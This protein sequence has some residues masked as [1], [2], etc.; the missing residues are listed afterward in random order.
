MPGAIAFDIFAYLDTFLQDLD[1]SVGD[2]DVLGLYS[3]TFV[4]GEVCS[5]ELTDIRG[6]VTS[7]DVS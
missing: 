7:R 3:Y 2:M 6:H 5:F 1:K 4:D